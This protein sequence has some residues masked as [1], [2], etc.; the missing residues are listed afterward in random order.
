M[1][2]AAACTAVLVAGCGG[3]NPSASGVEG[4]GSSNR[5][6]DT[7][8]S[9]DPPQTFS[10]TGV[11]LPKEAAY[12]TQRTTFGSGQ[13]WHGRPPITLHHTRAFIAS[14]YDLQAVDTGNGRV[15]TV[16]PQ[17]NP[18][19]SRQSVPSEELAGPPFISD[20]GDVAVPFAVRIPGSGTTPDTRAVELIVVDASSAA[21]KW[22]TNL[23]LPEWA[24][25]AFGDLT[26]KV[27]GGH[28]DIVLVQVS[29]SDF[30]E[31]TAY[32]VNLR[33]RRSLWQ[34][35]VAATAVVG[36]TVTVLEG[37]DSDRHL[38]ALDLATG[39]QAWADPEGATYVRAATAGPNLL[40]YSGRQ[41]TQG[42]YFA[43]FL[44]ARTG[45]VLND[46]DNISDITCTY[47]G[48]SVTVCSGDF[49]NYSDDKRVFAVDAT[50]GKQL[51]Q[52]PDAA[53]NRIAPTITAVWNG[54]AY[55]TAQR[56]AIALD[57]RTGADANVSPGLA[58]GLVNGY[59]GLTMEEDGT[60]TAHPAT[61]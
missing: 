44:D 3:S 17:Q 34:K 47:D 18:L 25:K 45:K 32:A 42:R 52:L 14:P 36:S 27:V 15:T 21:A 22:S 53:A 4:D 11:P 19:V 43:K 8:K 40:Q 51:W 2:A 59:T 39:E 5:K 50:T 16:L 28:S 6:Q 10:E 1:T 20:N 48:K 33:T 37:D 30:N 55:G 58:P 9:Y 41:H 35:N 46:I 29:R 56:R 7:R 12:G 54:R 13:G 57:A 24:Q 31:A 61:S 60:V 38:K 49:K 23:Q 26:V